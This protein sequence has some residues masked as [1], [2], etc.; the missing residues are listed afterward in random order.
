[1]G[2]S[3]KCDCMLLVRKMKTEFD[4]LQIDFA[5]SHHIMSNIHHQFDFAN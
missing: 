1:M 4:Q 3:A 2:L 5:W